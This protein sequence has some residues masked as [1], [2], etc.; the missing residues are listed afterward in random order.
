[1]ECVDDQKHIQVENNEENH[2]YKASVFSFLPAFPI[3]IF[4]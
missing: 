2:F 1:M 3:D 4:S